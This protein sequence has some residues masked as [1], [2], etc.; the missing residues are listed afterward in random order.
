[1]RLPNRKI[2]Y[3]RRQRGVV[4]FIS[5]IML[6]A[7]TLA[8]IALVRSVD[9]SNLIA[10]NL[11]FKQGA[12]LAADFAIETAH[13]W[14]WPGQNTA[15]LSNDSPA[16]GYYSF[17]PTAANQIKD[18][19]CT[20]N[21]WPSALGQLDWAKYPWTAAG[22][23]TAAIPLTDAAGNQVSYVIHRLCKNGN[24]GPDSTACVSATSIP[25][26]HSAG[27][28][29]AQGPTQ[30]YYRVTARV[31]GPRNTVSYVQAVIQI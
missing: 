26:C 16:N 4:L 29:C 11:A 31:T 17:T 30:Y 18:V 3:F 19:T 28:P 1:M 15:S 12:T 8:G 10:G 22:A 9:T 21:N 13:N 6:V 27:Q 5:L 24:V 7:M 23:C 2:H 20:T 25:Q 14:L